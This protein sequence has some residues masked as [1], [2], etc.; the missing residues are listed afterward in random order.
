MVFLSVLPDVIQ[1]F[2]K[3]M[4]LAELTL[5][6]GMMPLVLPA[7]RDGTV[8]FAVAAL[9][10]EAV[11]SDFAF[12]PLRT[13]E[14]VVVC[15]RGHQ[16]ENTTEWRDLMDSEWLMFLSPGSQH[17]HLLEHLRRKKL[18]IPGKIIKTN[19]FGVSW[20]LLTRSNALLACPSGMLA[21]EP[22]GK[23]VSRIPLRITLPP[24]TLGILTLRDTPLSLAA[25]V[26]ADQFRQEIVS[27]PAH[28]AA[29]GT[30]RTRK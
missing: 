22:Y 19:T 16:L 27:H 30:V 8:D 24:I 11:S 18:P 4:P 15:R 7:L 23:Q 12:E 28:H 10:H 20:N 21:V 17:S 9:A 14:T 1:R 26:L 13:L 2:R 5:E 3:R 29:M 6:E 25:S